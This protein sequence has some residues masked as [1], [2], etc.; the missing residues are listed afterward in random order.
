[1]MKM[2][3]SLD[4]EKILN[5]GK[6]SIEKI[7]QYLKNLFE[8]RGM[9]KDSEGWFTNGNFTTCGSL[10]IKLSQTEWFMENLIEWVWYDTEDDSTE[11]LKAHYSKEKISA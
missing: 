1:M 10:I 3:I 11:D 4:E 8:K 6:Y 5:E 2:L 7:N 9:E